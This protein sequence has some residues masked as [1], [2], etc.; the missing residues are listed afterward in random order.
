MKAR[1]KFLNFL[2]VTISVSFLLIFISSGFAIAKVKIVASLPDFEAIAKEIGGDKV[3]VKS[4]AKGYQDPHFV[5]AKPSFIRDLNRADLLIYQGL[6]LEIGWLPVLIT[7][8][9]NSKITSLS[10]PGRLD[11][12]TLISN[13]LEVPRTRIDR[14]MGDIHPF[15]NPHYML[16]PRNG[17]LVA[18]GIAERLGQIDPENASFYEDNFKQFADQLVKKIR[19]WEAELAPFKGTKIVAYHKS[20]DYFANWAGF[21]EVGWIEPKPGIPPT[22]SHVAQLIENMKNQNVKVVIAESFY[23]Q[24]TARIIAEKTGSEFL[25]VPSSVEAREGI[26]TYP[27]LFDTIVNELIAALSKVKNV[28][29][30]T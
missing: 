6:D 3:E 21:D 7:G 30:A 27:Q 20:W 18:R 11:A 8:S 2:F 4:I 24:K 13:I 22:P 14:S 25:V 17:I 10:S 26:D 19:V 23:P 1:K 5:D 12:S 15:G 28:E 16:D 9:R 29:K